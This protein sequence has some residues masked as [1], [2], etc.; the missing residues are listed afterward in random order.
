MSFMVVHP[1]VWKYT[2]LETRFTYIGLKTTESYC[3]TWSISDL[4]QKKMRRHLLFNHHSTHSPLWSKDQFS[5]TKHL[6]G[7]KTLGFEQHKFRDDMTKLVSWRFFSA[8]FRA[9]SLPPGL[10]PPRHRPSKRSAYPPSAHLVAGLDLTSRSLPVIPK[11]FGEVLVGC[12]FLPM[13]TG[14]SEST[15]CACITWSSMA[16]L[17][18]EKLTE[19]Y[20]S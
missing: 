9:C 13:E 8:F 10:R 14:R 5:G 11:F 19:E 18:G 17:N 2:Q 6:F 1:P 16:F 20:V 15:N 7:G 3:N 12:V 4:F